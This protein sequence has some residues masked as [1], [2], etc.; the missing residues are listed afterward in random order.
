MSEHPIE[1]DVC[2]KRT[3][4][5]TYNMI[6]K[7]GEHVV[8][9]S[10]TVVYRVHAKESPHWPY[11]RPI[12]AFDVDEEMVRNAPR[13]SG[14]LQPIPTFNNTLP[15]PSVT[16]YQSPDGT[17]HPY[18]LC[19]SVSVSRHASNGLEFT[20]TCNFVDE[21]GYET[22]Q[23]P[24]ETVEAI[25]AIK[26]YSFER[27]EV[28]AWTEDSSLA[29]PKQ[30][31]LPT[32][33]LYS[34]PPVKIVGQEVV[35]LTQYETVFGL[36]HILGDPATPGRLY[37]VNASAWTVET[38]TAYNNTVAARHAMISDIKFEEA[39]VLTTTGLVSAYRVTY[40]I[41]IRRYEL[42]S[43]ADNGSE[44]DETPGW[45]QPRI[46]A[47][48]RALDALSERRVPAANIEAWG[49]QQAYL[50]TTGVP[51]APVDQK[52]IPPYDILRLQPQINFNF[53]R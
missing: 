16:T 48:T 42:K 47:D 40:T 22:G 24:P 8:A 26:K 39:E 50:K 2:R 3:S 51:H 45:D 25:P 35:T 32:G 34:N 41:P 6:Q 27:F 43:L 53:L 52:G 12:E 49:N 19:T 10:I 31:V 11:S 13:Y 21:T 9:K 30:C 17:I 4:N 5:A 15:R 38:G 23:L 29:T 18:W 7:N 1:Y 14:T 33:T 44:I 46:R 36:E 20:V 28:T 37:S